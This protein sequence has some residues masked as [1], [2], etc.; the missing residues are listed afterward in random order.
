[1][2]K[3][4]EISNNN[5]DNEICLHKFFI[6]RKQ[7]MTIITTIKAIMAMNVN[8][9]QIR[10]DLST[11]LV[12]FNPPPTASYWLRWL[13]QKPSIPPNFLR[14]RMCRLH[15]YI[16]W[17]KCDPFANIFTGLLVSV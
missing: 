4:E 17:A 10:Y 12:T 6:Q 9:M 13:C 8:N 3:Q 16:I 14:Q 11:L 5:N 1:M 2:P 7:M 15:E